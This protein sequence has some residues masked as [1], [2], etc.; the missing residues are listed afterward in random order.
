QVGALDDSKESLRAFL[1][2]TGM[3]II[4]ATDA[5]DNKDSTSPD[6]QKR[7][8]SAA[9]YIEQMV[10]SVETKLSLQRIGP[11]GAFLFI[12]TALSLITTMED[13]LNRVFGAVRNRAIPRRILL[14]WS[15]MT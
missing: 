15:V 14:Y 1:Q 9:D 7:R 3:S 11:I 2:S 13:S 6:A 12:W 8:Q 4:Y 5:I 10:D